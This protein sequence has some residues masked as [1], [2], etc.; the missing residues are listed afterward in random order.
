MLAIVNIKITNKRIKSTKR[1]SEVV[2]DANSTQGT[3]ISGEIKHWH[4]VMVAK[5]RKER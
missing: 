5:C 2:N 3:C 4:I 1:M